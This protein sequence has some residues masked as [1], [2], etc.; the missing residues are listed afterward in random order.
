MGSGFC[1][2][3]YDITMSKRT[4]KP[5]LNSAIILDSS[6]KNGGESG[7]ITSTTTIDESKDNNDLKSSLKQLINGNEKVKSNFGHGEHEKKISK[8][9][10]INN[11]SSSSLGQHFS[12]DQEKQL[13][14]VTMK[15]KEGL[16]GMKLKKMVGRYA[17]VLT[18][19]IKAK[20]DPS[21]HKK[22][23]IRLKM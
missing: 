1:K 10:S 14:I 8:G 21:S 22:P 23:M 13:Q 9:R 16:Q 20:R 12:E 17:K 3:H 4:R 5:L 2:R 7:E 15:Q 6:S 19:L 11:T 18:S